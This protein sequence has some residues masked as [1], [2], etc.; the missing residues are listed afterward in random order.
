MVQLLGIEIEQVTAEKLR[1]YDG[2]ALVDV[3]PPYFGD[4]LPRVD[5]VVDHHPLVA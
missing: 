3:Q 2:I 4:I 1:H 5:A